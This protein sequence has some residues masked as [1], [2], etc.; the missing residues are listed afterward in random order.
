MNLVAERK[1]DELGRIVL[2]AEIRLKLGI[3]SN[4]SIK[5]Y[6]DNGKILLEKSKPS[7]K[8]CGSNEYINTDLH[9]CC[10]CISKIKQY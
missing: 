5:I 6:E 9:L 10:G 2:P 7:C 3:T 4:S 1:V 8:L